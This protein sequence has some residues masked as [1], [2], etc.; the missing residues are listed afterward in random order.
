VLAP[1][2]IFLRGARNVYGPRALPRQDA[3]SGLP[4]HRRAREL[5]GDGHARRLDECSRADRFRGQLH[6][7]RH[8]DAAAPFVEGRRTRM[9]IGAR[10]RTRRLRYRLCL[11]GATSNAFRRKRLRRASGRRPVPGRVHGSPSVLWRHPR[12]PRL[13]ALHMR[14][15]N[16]GSVHGLRRRLPRGQSDVGSLLRTSRH[17]SHARCVQSGRPAGRLPIEGPAIR[18]LLYAKPGH[19]RR[20]RGCGPAHDILLLAVVTSPRDSWAS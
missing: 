19:G 7:G 6:A 10:Q 5:R 17:L 15:R 14:R 18:R 11:Y 1:D 4:T 9:H 20:Q 13:F 12:H 3:Y 8:E 16:G 2:S